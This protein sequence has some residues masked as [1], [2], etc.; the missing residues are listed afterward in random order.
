MGRHEDGIGV[1]PSMYPNPHD[2]MKNKQGLNM[3]P[4]IKHNNQQESQSIY[5]LTLFQ[6]MTPPQARR[7][8]VKLLTK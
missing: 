4:F 5:V 3:N 7:K 1:H 2:K 8:F 6:L